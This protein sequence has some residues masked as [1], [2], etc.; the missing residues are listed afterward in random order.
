MRPGK[1]MMAA[2]LIWS[3]ISAGALAVAEEAARDAGPVGQ[4]RHPISRKS[5]ATGLRHGDRRV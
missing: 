4:G 5:R 2:I 3:A 1:K